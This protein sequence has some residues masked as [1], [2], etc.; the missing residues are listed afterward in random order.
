MQYI[1]SLTLTGLG[2]QDHTLFE[3]IKHGVIMDF[4]LFV[5][6]VNSKKEMVHNMMSYW[7]SSEGG[8]TSQERS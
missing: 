5:E 2:G 1:L 4:A 7:T 8:R 6:E 3:R